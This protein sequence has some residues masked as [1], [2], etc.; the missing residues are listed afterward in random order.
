MKIYVQKQTRMQLCT[1]ALFIM[2]KNL[3]KSGYPSL[4]DC[5]SK[6]EYIHIKASRIHHANIC[7]SGI[8]IISISFKKRKIEKT[9]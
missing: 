1:A 6:V 7:L 2:A 5:T 9:E 4:D 3:K 8:R